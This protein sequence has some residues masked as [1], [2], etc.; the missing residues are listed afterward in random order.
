VDLSLHQLVND[1][2]HLAQATA[3]AGQLAD[4]QTIPRRQQAQQFL[5]APLVAPLPGGGLRFD[6]AVDAEALLPR[7]V[8][9][10]E[11]LV[12][13][14]LGTGGNTQ[15]GDGFHGPGYEKV[16]QHFY[17]ANMDHNIRFIL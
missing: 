4:D 7:V 17:P 1:L 5:D 9:D 2:D 10:G 6:E 15:V 13:Q 16:E 8:E 12:G 3:Q 11:L 14:V